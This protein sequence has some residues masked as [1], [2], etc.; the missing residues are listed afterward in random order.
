MVLLGVVFEVILAMANIGTA[1]ALFPAARRQNES[2]ALGYVGLRTLEAA[3]I[4]VGVIPLLAVVTLR[5]SL[6]GA[7]GADTAGLVTLGSALVESYRW[8]LVVGPGL[9]CGTNTV[10]MA[11]LLYRSGLVPRVIPMLGLIGGPLVFAYHTARMFLFPGQSPV[12][13][14]IL[15]IPIFTWEVSLALRLIFKGFNGSALRGLPASTP[16]ADEL[17][18]A[19]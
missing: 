12:W 17:L 13:A 4:A 6:A 16:A 15:V 19:A 2:L 7:T 5:Q 18:S 3:V 8:T 1:V 10:V 11:Y 14:A 9:I